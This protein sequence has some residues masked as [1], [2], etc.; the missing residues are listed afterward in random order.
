MGQAL[1]SATVVS[2]REVD[3]AGAAAGAV[4]IVWASTRDGSPVGSAVASANASPSRARQRDRARTPALAVVA[5]VPGRAVG[6]LAIADRDPGTA[7]PC[8]FSTLG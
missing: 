3:P 4:W 2:T 7:L 8:T 5:R 1:K 6:A